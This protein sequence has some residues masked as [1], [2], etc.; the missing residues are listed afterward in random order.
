MRKI[1]P[2]GMVERFRPARQAHGKTTQHA[3]SV[4]KPTLRCWRDH[5]RVQVCAFPSHL[6]SIHH[7]TTPADDGVMVVMALDSVRILVVSFAIAGA[8]AG[9]LTVLHAVFQAIHGL[10]TKRA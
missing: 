1:D 4:E 10:L 8:M 2:V 9:V 7:V 3:A 5:Q 6:R